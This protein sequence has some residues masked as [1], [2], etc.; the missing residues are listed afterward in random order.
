MV[1]KLDKIEVELMVSKK[2]GLWVGWW[3]CLALRMVD[4]LVAWTV[5]SLAARWDDCWAVHLGAYWV[6]SWDDHLVGLKVWNW[7]V[8]TDCVLVVSMV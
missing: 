1:V 6:V 8:W 5:C 2:A 4:C 3:V 7:A